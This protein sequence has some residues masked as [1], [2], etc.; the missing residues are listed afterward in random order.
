MPSAPDG[1]ILYAE[2]QIGDSRIMLND[3]ITGSKSPKSPSG[4]PASLWIYV[5]DCDAFFERALSVGAH[6]FGGTMGRVGSVL[7]RQE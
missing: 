7:R 5:E 4:S 1:K 6:V 2:I 3:P